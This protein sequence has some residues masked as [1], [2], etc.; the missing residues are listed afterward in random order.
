MGHDLH[1]ILF[2]CTDIIN[3]HEILLK[4]REIFCDHM[5]RN[6][7]KGAKMFVSEQTVHIPY[8]MFVKGARLTPRDKGPPAQVFY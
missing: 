7:T 8:R 4:W 5:A 3:R 1:E 2:K 6:C